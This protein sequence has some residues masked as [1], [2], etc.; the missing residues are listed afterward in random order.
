[1]PFDGAG[2]F[3]RTPGTLIA[4]QG[5][6]VSQQVNDETN[7]LVTGVNGKVNLD[8]KLAMTG[9]QLLSG[10]GTSPLHA[11][12]VQQAQKDVL[13]HAVTVAGTVDAIQLTFTPTTTTWTL[14]EKIRFKSAGANTLTTPTIS[15]DGGV[16]NITVVKG[17]GVAVVAGDIGASGTMHELVYNGTTLTL[18]NPAN[19]TGYASLSA[20]N[21]FTQDQGISTSAGGNMVLANSTSPGTA[22]EFLGGFFFRAYNTTPALFNAAD[23][24]GQLIT[25]T[26][27]S[28]TGQLNFDTYQAGAYAT[29]LVVG[30]G[31]VAGSAT[32]GD[33]GLGTV[34]AT[35]LY[36]NGVAVSGFRVQMAAQN[37]TSGTSI[38][39]TSIPSG[40]IRITISLRAMSTSGTANYRIQIGA[41]SVQT[42][43]YNSSSWVSGG[44]AITSTSGF[45]LINRGAA[46]Q[47][48]G[49]YTL[50]N[51][52]SNTWVIAGSSFD[53][54][55]AVAPNIETGYTTLSGALDR[56]RITTA[57]GTDTFDNGVIDVMYEG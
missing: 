47:M 56:V 55:A 53:S 32:G 7:N 17:S 5:A 51:Q 57:N 37:S 19:I 27:G 3:S 43:S 10:D 30:N 12:T 8:G 24:R 23:I 29:R 21:T 34:N 25:P 41:G 28:E 36:T 40:V 18:L 11:A 38:D 33:K 16:T 26:A 49:I 20:N 46:A 42:T 4:N 45:D 39:F 1:M 2:N 14:N 44:A 31:L 54:T 6:L 9:L 52:G 35:G 13:K 15:K 22:S 48:T 50:V